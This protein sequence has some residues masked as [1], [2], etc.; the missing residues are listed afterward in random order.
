MCPSA[1]RVLGPTG[2]GVGQT[3][4]KTFLEQVEMCMQN[5]IRIVAWVWIFISSPYT[6]RHMYLYAHFF[7]HRRYIIKLLTYQIF[8]SSLDVKKALIN[9]G[10]FIFKLYSYLTLILFCNLWISRFVFFV[11]MLKAAKSGVKPGPPWWWSDAPLCHCDIPTKNKTQECHHSGV[12]TC[13]SY[14]SSVYTSIHV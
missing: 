2:E 8:I 14:F 9:F 7:I 10:K 4:T 12:T 1:Y 5:F 6:N 3:C 11:L 13:I